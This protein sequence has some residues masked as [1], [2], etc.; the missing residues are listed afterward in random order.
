M[1]VT[2]RTKA[3]SDNRESLYLDFYPPIVNPET[4]KP[5]RREFLNLHLYTKPKNYIDKN[6]NKETLSL[7]ETI[8]A[9]R[10][11]DIHNRRFGFL[12]AKKFEADFIQFFKDECDK[13]E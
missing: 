8:K 5:T 10:Q 3:I 13:R 4:G 11:I 7:A 2:L 6:H 9:Q 1:K 12:A